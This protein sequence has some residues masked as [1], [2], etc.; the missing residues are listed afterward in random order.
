VR[1]G[2]C[3]PVIHRLADDGV[4]TGSDLFG[5]VFEDPIAEVSPA[6]VASSIVGIVEGDGFAEG[7]RRGLLNK[8]DYS[9]RGN[10]PGSMRA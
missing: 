4:F 8:R 2:A 7:S 1:K 10:L 5:D 3:Q 9:R 6:Y